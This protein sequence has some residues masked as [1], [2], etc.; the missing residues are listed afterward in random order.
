P[1]SHE[2]DVDPLPL[3]IHAPVIQHGAHLPHDL[4]RSEVALHAQQGGEAELAI[5]GAAHLAGNAYRGAPPF[6]VASFAAV[7]SLAAIALGHPYS[8]NRLPVGHSHEIAN[9]SVIGSEAP[10]LPRLADR[11]SLALQSRT[12]LLGQG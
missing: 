11:K 9:G 4:S 3:Q 8:L 10:V 2:N 5:H 6:S 12:K 1:H 7:S